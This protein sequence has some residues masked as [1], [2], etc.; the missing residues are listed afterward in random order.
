MVEILK[1]ILGSFFL[2]GATDMIGRLFWKREDGL[3]GRWLSWLISFF[4]IVTPLFYVLN[5]L[6]LQINYYSVVSILILIWFGTGIIFRRKIF[7]FEKIKIKGILFWLLA[8]F[9]IHLIFYSIYFTIPEWDSYGNILTVRENILNA[10]ITSNYRPLFNASMTI[11]SLASFI[12]PYALFPILLIIAQ[13]S[14]LISIY[15]IS[16]ANKNKALNNLLMASTLAVPVINME[17]DVPRPQSVLMILM[18]IFFY[19]LYKYIFSKKDILDFLLLLWIPI[20]GISYHEF[21]LSLLLVAIILLI[22]QLVEVW[23][24]GDKKDKTIVL[25]IIIIAFLSAF[26]GYNY[27]FTLRVTL[28]NLTIIFSNFV[29][30]FKWSWWFL[31]NEYSADQ[32]SVAWNGWRSVLTY[33]AYYLSPII[34]GWLIFLIIKIFKN[35]KINAFHYYL[36]ISGSIFFVFA[37]VLPRMNIGVLPERSW[38]FF[39]ITVLLFTAN[40][41][42]DKKISSPLRLLFIFLILISLFGSYIVADGKKSLTTSEEMKATEWIKGNTTKESIFISQQANNKLIEFFGGRKMISPNSDFFL[43]DKLIEQGDVSICES[44]K[45]SSEIETA[46]NGLL[47]FDIVS[48]DV[49]SLVDLVVGTRTNIQKFKS[50]C[51]PRV[52]FTHTPMYILFSTNKLDGIYST[53]KW[54]RD[55]NYYGANLEKFN[56]LPL[57]YDY[58]GVKIWK[59]K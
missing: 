43:S 41:V 59:L 25:L 39:D 49:K 48:G 30:N 14:L 1:G 34:F 17:I 20:I 33:Y 37:E 21:F 16:R 46:K 54:W 12:D 2:I 19:F 32:M 45:I 10:S 5:L 47:N 22:K 29:N 57:V 4:T 7:E 42:K 23:L 6:K 9:A 56:S 8:Y 24:R 40:Y 3:S 53:R 50:S 52:I 28:A 51:Y 38:L 18:P 58:G 44:N 26:L 11:S 55:V 36:I 13:S 27:V 15:L 31:S 35:Y